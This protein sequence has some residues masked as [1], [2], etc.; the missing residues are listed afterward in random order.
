MTLFD[1]FKELTGKK[2]DWDSFTDKEKESFNPYMV[3]RFL[4]MH[5]PFIELINYVQTIP[6]TDKKKYYTVY[7]GLLPKQNVW[8]K[9]IKPKMKQPTPELINAICG[10]LNCSKREAREEVIL[11][12]NDVLE[13]NLYR[14]GYQPSE[15]AKMFK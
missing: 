7:C 4:S 3:N 12:D 1:W 11:L 15:V 13:E 2:R 5:Q 6:Y 10:I 9:Y 14:A 8:L